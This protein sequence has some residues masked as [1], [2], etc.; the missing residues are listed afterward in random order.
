MPPAPEQG[1]EIGAQ[2]GVVPALPQDPIVAGSDV[3]LGNQ[4]HPRRAFQTVRGLELELDSE[5]GAVWAVHLLREDDGQAPAPAERDKA[6]DGGDDRGSTGR[7]DGRPGI[8]EVPLH[9]DDQD[10]APRG[11]E[12]RQGLHR[13]HSSGRRAA[14]ARAVSRTPEA[15][16]SAP[17]PRLRLRAVP[18][19]MA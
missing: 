18:L 12:G 8:D 6:I 16:L 5:V 14:A 1:L 3:Q 11:I 4:V 10:R 13:S 19:T 2:E 9:V 7:R 15:R 17:G